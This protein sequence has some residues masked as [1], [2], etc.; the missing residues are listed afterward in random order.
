MSL[1]LIRC[2]IYYVDHEGNPAEILGAKPVDRNQRYYEIDT[3]EGDIVELN[4]DVI[5]KVV[6]YYE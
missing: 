3:M 2:N 6:Y 1:R 4:H 5:N